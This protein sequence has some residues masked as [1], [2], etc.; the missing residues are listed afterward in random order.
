MP[1]ATGQM[2]K[3]SINGTKSV[4][5]KD[6]VSINLSIFDDLPSA[7]YDCKCQNLNTFVSEYVLTQVA[8]KY[9]LIVLVV[10][11]SVSFPVLA[12]SIGSSHLIS[13]VVNLYLTSW[14]AVP[15]DQ[16]IYRDHLR[17]WWLI[18]DQKTFSNLWWQHSQLYIYSTSQA[19]SL[20]MHATTTPGFKCHV[21]IVT[22]LVF[23]AR[24]RVRS[25]YRRIAL[26]D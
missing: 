22:P 10:P 12:T 7:V 8:S 1:S 14:S 6:N 3:A 9:L 23:C 25:F 13:L 11:G 24:G 17:W 21:L 5:R 20:K 26:L 2:S 15:P 19:W 4:P 16:C 18:T